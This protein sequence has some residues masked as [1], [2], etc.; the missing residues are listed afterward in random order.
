MC[1][2][3]LHL[4]WR[5]GQPSCVE[6]QRGE[7]AGGLEYLLGKPDGIVKVFDLV[8]IGGED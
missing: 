1:C 2:V 5:A 4:G 8:Y 3:P 7:Q 6:S